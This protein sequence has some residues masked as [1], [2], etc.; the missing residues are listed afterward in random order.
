MLGAVLPRLLG[1]VEGSRELAQ[2]HCRAEAFPAQVAP[3]GQEGRSVCARALVSREHRRLE[4]AHVGRSDGRSE[5]R[6]EDNFLQ[7]REG[8][9]P[10]FSRPSE[11]AAS[12]RRLAEHRVD[13]EVPVCA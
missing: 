6:L 3:G 9:V 10:E 4:V 1:Q 8:V 13:E 7:F 2:G 5:L 12:V 11:A